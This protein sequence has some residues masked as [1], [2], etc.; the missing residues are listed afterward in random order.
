MCVDCAWTIRTSWCEH[1]GDTSSDGRETSS[2]AGGGAGQ[3]VGET[4]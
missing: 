2:G 1:V 3:T 4:H